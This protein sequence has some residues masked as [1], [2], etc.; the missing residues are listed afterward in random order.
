MLGT[1]LT[2]FVWG[3]G[4]GVG[5]GIRYILCIIHKIFHVTDIKNLLEID[6][7]EENF[8]NASF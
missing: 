5:A 2:E 7:L 8:Y 6:N 4:G 3:G 1:H